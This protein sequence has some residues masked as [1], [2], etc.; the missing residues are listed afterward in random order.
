MQ[1]TPEKWRPNLST[2]FHS[3]DYDRVFFPSRMENFNKHFLDKWDFLKLTG[4]L[5]GVLKVQ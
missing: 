5:H 4:L 2:S 3:L 1:E